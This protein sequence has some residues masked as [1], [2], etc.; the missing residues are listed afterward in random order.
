MKDKNKNKK[1][2][3]FIIAHVTVANIFNS[4]WPAS[5]FADNRTAKLK[6]LIKKDIT[7]TQISI[8]AINKGTFTG[9]KTLKSFHP[10]FFK[11]I[12][13]IEKKKL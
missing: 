10:F 13:I 1:L 2:P 11:P 6:G 9:R 5:I 7:S 4:I 12:I 3:L 8:G